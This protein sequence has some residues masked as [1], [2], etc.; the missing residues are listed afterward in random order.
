MYSPNR[1]SQLRTV[2]FEERGMIIPLRKR[3]PLSTSGFQM[4]LCD[5]NHD[6]RIRGGTGISR[7]VENLIRAR[8]IRIRG[9][10]GCGGKNC[11]CCSKFVR[12]GTINKFLILLAL[13]MFFVWIYQGPNYWS[14]GLQKKPSPCG[15]ATWKTSFHR[16]KPEALLGDISLGSCQ[17]SVWTKTPIKL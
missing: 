5:G 16:R 11:R 15:W 7:G 4:L 8:S 1:S 6:H 9:F 13:K 10:T 2:T 12:L 3:R 14:W 17:I